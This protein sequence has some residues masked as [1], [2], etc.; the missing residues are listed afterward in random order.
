MKLVG[1]ERKD[2]LCAL[3]ESERTT[4]QKV[5]EQNNKRLSRD[6]GTGT[7]PEAD[8][9][10]E[11]SCAHVGYGQV[12]HNWFCSVTSNSQPPTA[13]QPAPGAAASA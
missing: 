4:T 1:H 11:W 9:S 10:W 6:Y 2:E 8:E 13:K 3:I 12:H 7:I 5:Q